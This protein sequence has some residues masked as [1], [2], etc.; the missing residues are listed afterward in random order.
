MEKAGLSLEESCKNAQTEYQKGC[1]VL[2]NQLVALQAKSDSLR[3]A[4]KIW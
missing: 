3:K 2:Q 1:G 4:L